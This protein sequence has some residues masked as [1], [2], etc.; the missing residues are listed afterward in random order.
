MHV[1]TYSVAQLRLAPA[2]HLLLLLYIYYSH[3]LIFDHF[4][5][6]AHIKQIQEP[7]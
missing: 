3:E 7:R 6:R 5:L 2:K 4:F 1:T